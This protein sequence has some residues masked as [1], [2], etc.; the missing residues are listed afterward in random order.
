MR[1][2]HI[3]NPEAQLLSADVLSMSIVLSMSPPAPGRAAC[4]PAGCSQHV[5]VGVVSDCR[6]QRSR[7][8]VVSQRAAA[9]AL[10]D[11]VSLLW[12]V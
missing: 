11:V 5:A 8:A 6:L 9:A 2:P 10:C 12:S 1:G 3:Q 4:V 7:L